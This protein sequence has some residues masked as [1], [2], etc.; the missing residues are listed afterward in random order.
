MHFLGTALM[1]RQPLRNSTTDLM[2]EPPKRTSLLNDFECQCMTPCPGC[3]AQLLPHR[4]NLLPYSPPRS[5]LP[6]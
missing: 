3:T 5:V 6:L 1:H 2:T 4:P